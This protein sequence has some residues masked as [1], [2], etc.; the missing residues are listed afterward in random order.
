[1]GGLEIFFEEVMA[2]QTLAHDYKGSDFCSG[3]LFGIHG[4]RM[5]IGIGKYMTEAWE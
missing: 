4:S 5:V 1:M 2:F 3:L